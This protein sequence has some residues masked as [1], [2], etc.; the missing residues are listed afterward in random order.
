MNYLQRGLLAGMALLILFSASACTENKADSLTRVQKAKE[1]SFAMS[2]GYPPF[3]FFNSENT[4]V[5]FDIDVAQELARRMGVAFKPVTTDW[6][7]I[8]EGLRAGTYD[9]IL[10]SM[11]VTEQRLKVV[12][13]SI[14][15]YF[16]GAQ[17][18]VRKDSP[19][20]SA[21]DLQGK[22][23]GVVTGT[24]FA[25]D[26]A[27]LGAKEVKLYKDDTQTLMELNN[28]V[29]DG[30]ITDRV[31]GA[32]AMNSDRFVLSMLGSPL[33]SEDIAVA[34]RKEDDTLLKKINEE[35]AAMHKDGTLS[36]ISR[37]WLH[38]DITVQ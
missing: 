28:R 6:S 24:T 5:G 32:N 21:K 23:I 13:F 2:G 34:L 27:K 1:I 19:I 7:G 37:K 38:T 29:V 8:I 33:R 35:L 31:V 11:A 14:P 9:G 4:L 15:Y 17:V 16:S 10:G 12:N 36:A 20:K 3:N 30:V 18:M 25:D 26:A 22:I